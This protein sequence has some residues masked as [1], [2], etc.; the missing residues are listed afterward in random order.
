MYPSA[1]GIYSVNAIQGNTRTLSS[2]SDDGK[3]HR[4]SLNPLPIRYLGSMRTFS[5]RVAVNSEDIQFNFYETWRTVHPSQELCT[6]GHRLEELENLTLERYS[7][8]E[9]ENFPLIIL[10]GLPMNE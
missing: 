6:E 5:S 2:R 9:F 1:P 4:D 7:A 3:R 10:E 8:G